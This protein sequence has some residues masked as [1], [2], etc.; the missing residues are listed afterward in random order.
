MLVPV[1]STLEI[2]PVDTESF[3]AGVAVRSSTPAGGCSWVGELEHAA[4]PTV[5]IAVQI[6]RMG[7]L[8]FFIL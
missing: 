1:T 4:R 6:A 8:R 7:F 3:C 5:N 2:G